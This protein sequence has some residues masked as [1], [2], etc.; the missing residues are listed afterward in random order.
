MTTSN[1]S[2]FDLLPSLIQLHGRVDSQSILRSF[3]NKETNLLKLRLLEVSAIGYGYAQD[4]TITITDKTKEI[5]FGNHAGLYSTRVS[6]KNMIKHENIFI[7]ELFFDEQ[8]KRELTLLEKG[9]QE[10]NFIELRNTLK[11]KEFQ[12]NG[13]TAIMYGVS[14]GGKTSGVH[15]I[16]KKN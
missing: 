16:A 6:N 2:T 1:V 12:N 8:V 10:D 3:I 15:Q 4:L 9:L 7:K 14:G 11:S 13:V 5:F